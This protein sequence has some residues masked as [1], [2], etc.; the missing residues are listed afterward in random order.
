MRVCRAMLKVLQVHVC[1]PQSA[2]SSQYLL[3]LLSPSL[4][5]VDSLLSDHLRLR[6]VSL[7]AFLFWLILCVLSSVSLGG[8]L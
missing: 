3:G 8:L 6:S 4:T 5:G 7:K 2:S 1:P